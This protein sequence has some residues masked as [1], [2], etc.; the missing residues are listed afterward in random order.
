MTA[1][2]TAPV[3]TPVLTGTVG[4]GKSAVAAEINGT[5]AA[6]DVRDALVQQ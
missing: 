5:L 6:F 1:D 3:P 2:R 4:S